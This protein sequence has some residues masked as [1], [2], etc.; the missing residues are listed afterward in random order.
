MDEKYNLVT[1]AAYSKADTIFHIIASFFCIKICMLEHLVLFRSYTV[2]N[3]YFKEL[4]L[5]ASFY[6]SATT[7]LS[8]TSFPPLP[9]LV[10]F[11]VYAAKI[12]GGSTTTSV[13]RMS[14]GT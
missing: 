4:K 5:Y 13:R 6:I 3:K 14:P 9:G 8:T 1:S 10:L 11:D 7:F 2:H 12:L